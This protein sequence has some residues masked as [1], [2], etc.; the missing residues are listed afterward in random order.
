[1]KS[2]TALTGMVLSAFVLSPFA[3]SHAAEPRAVE[4]LRL[5]VTSGLAVHHAAS[6]IVRNLF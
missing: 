2:R 5:S 3:A 6:K 4:P 1:M